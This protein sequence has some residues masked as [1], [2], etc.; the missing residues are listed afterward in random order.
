LWAHGRAVDD[1]YAISHKI[2]PP[3]ASDI[4]LSGNKIKPHPL[5]KDEIKTY[6]AAYAQ[7]AINS[8]EK[9]GFDA[10]E[11]HFAN[12]YLPD[13]FLQDVSN[14]RTDEYGGS[15]ENRARFLLEIFEAVV[16]AVGQKKVGFRL[17]PWS[18]FQGMHLDSVYVF[19]GCPDE[20]SALDMRMKDPVPT[21]SY[22][23]GEVKKLYPD[24]LYLHV[25]EPRISG[26]DDVVNHPYDTSRDSNNFIRDIW[27]PKPL[28]SAGGYDSE[29]AAKAA[30]QDGELI[31]FGR[32][33]LA[34]VRSHLASADLS[35]SSLLR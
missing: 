1:E 31:A 27:A 4:P 15:I 8:V 6:I 24:L 5:T 9:A 29:T 7:A 13:Q 16:K 28:I 30:E 34:N 17:S 2:T 21:F 19:P 33:F 11:L 18:P 20:I 12:G 35:L 26:G 3:S 22:L 14:T 25:I 23:V 10:V 32:H